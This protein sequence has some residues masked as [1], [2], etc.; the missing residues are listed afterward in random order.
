MSEFNSSR[1]EW[2]VGFDQDGCVRSV[3][4]NPDPQPRIGDLFPMV[5]QPKR[6]AEGRKIAGYTPVQRYF[7]GYAL[8]WL[9]EERDALLRQNLL[10]DVHAPAKWRV[11]GPL[12]NIPEFYEAF[13]VMA[14]Q[15][16]YRAPADRVQIW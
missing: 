16:L 13:D 9:F 7:L 5:E 6:D 15:A 2:D 1:A 12:S 14:G 4:R 10:S 8:S 3:P 11:N